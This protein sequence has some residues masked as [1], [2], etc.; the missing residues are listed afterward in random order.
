MDTM[1]CILCSS[2][3][4]K[5]IELYDTR[6]GYDGYFD[7]LECTSCGHKFLK[8]SFS[9]DQLVRLY[10]DYYPRSSFDLNNFAP[11]RTPHGLGAWLNGVSCSA[12]CWIPDNVKVLDIGCGFGESLGY[13]AARG[14]DVYGVEADENIRCV[15]AK[16]GF[17]VHVGLFDPSL[18]ESDFFDYV[19]LDQVIEHT[20]DP[21]LMLAGI[22][23]V[24]KSGGELIVSTPNSNGW[25]A[26]LF[27]ARWINWHAP[28]HLQHFSEHSMRIS[29]DK[30]GLVIESCRTQTSSEWLHYQWISLLITSGMG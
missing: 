28:Y 6:Y 9:Q 2:D 24:L 27:G 18:Y 15:A 25:G 26:K 3:S 20:I 17:K 21:V 12:Y 10:S 7:L 11:A 13:H 29:A 1:N 19:T 30:A 14:C 8:A 4:K 23:S 5:R 22:A 16:Y